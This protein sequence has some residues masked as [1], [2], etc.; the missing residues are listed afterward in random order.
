MRKELREAIIEYNKK[1]LE[2]DEKASDLD[3]IVKEI[4]KLPYGQLKNVLT[5]EV[6]EVLAKYGISL[7]GEE[8]SE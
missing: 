1:V 3:V 8:A 5:T 4:L 7:I 6:L 2:S